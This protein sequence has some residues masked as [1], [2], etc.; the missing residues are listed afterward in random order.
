MNRNSLN[1]GFD[2]S[3]ADG[4]SS[5]DSVRVAGRQEV[6]RRDERNV[7]ESTQEMDISMNFLNFFC[8]H[9]VFVHILLHRNT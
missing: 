7:K 8:I 5:R 4:K 2:G 9:L 3:D 6:D 1:C